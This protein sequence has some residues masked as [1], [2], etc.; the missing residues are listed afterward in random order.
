M[1]LMDLSGRG[2]A[3]CG[4]TTIVVPDGDNCSIGQVMEWW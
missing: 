1:D 4:I 2:L 3:A